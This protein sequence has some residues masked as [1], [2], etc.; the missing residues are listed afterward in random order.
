MAPNHLKSQALLSDYRTQQPVNIALFGGTFDPIHTGHL[1]AAKTAA[2]KYA[3]DQILFVPTGN[4]PHK[5][6]NELTPYVHRYSMVALACADDLRFVPSLL[7]RPRPDSRPHYSIATVK[8]AKKNLR[9][10]DHL[11]FLI[12]L[13][14]FLDLRAWKEYRRLL[15]AVNF[16]VV[17][18]PGFESREIREVVPAG[19]VASGA[20]QRQKAELRLRHSRLYVLRGVKSPIASRNIREAVRRRQSITGLVPPLVEQYILKEGLYRLA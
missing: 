4:P 3:L 11:Y 18:R 5:V 13:D 6:G 8:R 1:W 19:L 10:W 17:S 14:A 12:G 2:R 16:I 20:R 15:D 7:E 9:T